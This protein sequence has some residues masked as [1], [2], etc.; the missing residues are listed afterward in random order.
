MNEQGDI[1]V[2][3]R[4][5]METSRDLAERLREYAGSNSIPLEEDDSKFGGVWFCPCCASSLKEQKSCFRCVGC[6]RG[7]SKPTAYAVVE[8][9]PHIK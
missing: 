1:F 5:E 9:H 6:G 7:L 4:G 2:C 3:L 8:F